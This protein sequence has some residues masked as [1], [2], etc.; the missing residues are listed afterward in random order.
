MGTLC[1][2]ILQLADEGDALGLQFLMGYPFLPNRRNSASAKPTVRLS[3]Q[4]CAGRDTFTSLR[5]AKSGLWS[6]RHGCTGE[7]TSRLG[8]QRQQDTN[9]ACCFVAQRYSHA[10][11]LPV[12]SIAVYSLVR[13]C[14]G[15][16]RQSSREGGSY[17]NSH[18]QINVTGSFQEL[19]RGPG[20]PDCGRHS[21]NLKVLQV[22][23]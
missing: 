5:C 8:Q 15:L 17:P 9:V 2:R 12:L 14:T 23:S 13:A 4:A 18:W 11:T 6:R 1:R 21:D 16:L 10:A 22:T 3:R 20:V 19:P 7:G